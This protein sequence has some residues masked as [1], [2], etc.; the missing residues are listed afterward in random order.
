MF[1]LKYCITGRYCPNAPLKKDLKL[2]LGTNGKFKRDKTTDEYDFE[3][4]FENLRSTLPLICG[5]LSIE[6][7]FECLVI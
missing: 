1:P 6:P 3:S 7:F 5:L 2:F 4:L